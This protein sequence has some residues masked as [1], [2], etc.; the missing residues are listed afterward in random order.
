MITIGDIKTVVIPNSH[1]HRIVEHSKKAEIGGI[2]HIR[3]TGDRKNNLSVD[4]LVG[5]YGTYA[6]TQYLIGN[7]ESYFDLREEMDKNPTVGDGGCD[8]VGTKIDIKTSLMRKSK[9]PLSYRL[10]VRPRERH[11]DWI[12]VLGL[13]PSIEPPIEV[14]LVGW[15]KD[16]N[17]N[18]HFQTEGVFAGAYTVMASELKKIPNKTW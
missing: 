2:S 13:I 15:E 18:S 7:V 3:T 5:Q 14:Y 1:Y 8:I 6:L 17:L 11:P 9:N 4:Q 16:D 10:A 12:Y